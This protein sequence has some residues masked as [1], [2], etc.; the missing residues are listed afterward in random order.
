MSARLVVLACVAPLSALAWDSVCYDANGRACSPSAGPQTARQRWVGPSDEHRQL[1]ELTREQ[2]GLPASVSQ[3]VT[4]SVWTSS[5]SVDLGG[6]MA[7]T[8]SPAPFDQATRERARTFTVAELAQ[9]PDF[10]Y[11]LWDW[12]NGHE[13]CPLAD[14]T[15]AT[16]CHDFASHMGPVNSNHFVPQSQRAYARAHGLALARAAEC[17]AVSDALG[18]R[19]PEVPRA[20]EVEALSLEAMAQHYLQDAWSM[21][22]MWQRWGSS[23]LDEFPGASTEAKRDHAVLTALVSGF[24]HGARGVLQALPT[25]TTYDV[26]DALCAPWDDVRFV[27]RDGVVSQAVGDLYLGQMTPTQR[28]RL[29]SC[30]TS[31]VRAVYAATGQ[32]HGPLGAVASGLSSVD[33]ASDFCFGQRATNEAIVRGMAIQLKVVSVQTSIPLDARFSS[34]MVPQVARAS[35]KVPVSKKTKN[36]FRLSLERVTTIARLTA[37][38]DPTGT[39]LAEG[40]MGDFLGV[41]PNGTYAAPTSSDDPP[42]PWGPGGSPR[43]L[44]L[45]QAF[46]TAHAK[47]WCA[48][49]TRP[50]LDALKVRAQDT[51][52]D[53]EARA[54]TCAVCTELVSRHLRV[55]TP[56]S[57]DTTAEPL[58]QAL[59]PTPAFVYVSGPGTTRALAEQWCCR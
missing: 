22:H 21:G 10:S 15:D 25:W 41:A 12:A 51:T 42:L 39:S 54:A 28:E 20:C 47:E 37:K 27:T 56:A 8:L 35:G 58:C 44:T 46:H 53:A 7:P 29:L 3:P 36:A 11:A 43:A 4:L 38:D 24:I 50:Q 34:W 19:F 59:T 23:N 5:S 30:A 33:P 16:L 13:S 1:F 18:A 45:A 40:A 6:V 57:W 26:N 14:G 32:A 55:G 17:K 48:A 9:L 52:L 49:M 31:G 2:A